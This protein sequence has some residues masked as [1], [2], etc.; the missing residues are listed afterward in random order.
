MNESLP[1][2]SAQDDDFYR[3][4]A[5]RLMIQIGVVQ[6][7]IVAEQEETRVLREDTQRRLAD[8][9]ASLGAPL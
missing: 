9:F 4:E 8:I 7:Q 2:E 5:Q 3:S 6:Q 1:V